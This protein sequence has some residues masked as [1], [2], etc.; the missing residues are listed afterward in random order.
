M[1]RVALRNLRAH[2]VRLLLSL[3]AVVLGVAFVSGSFVLTD[4]LKKTF[5]DLFTQVSSDVTVSPAPA[6]PGANDNSDAGA[7]LPATL[8]DTISKVPGVAAADGGIFV[9][10]VQ[11]I[12]SDGKQVGTSQAPKFGLD[13]NGNEALSPLRLVEGVGPTAAGQIAI[14]SQTAEKGGIKVGDTVTVLTPT[15]SGKNDVVGIFRFGTTGNLA[16]ASLTAF[17]QA[18]AEKLLTSPG[19]ITTVDIKAAD[20]VTQDEL[21]K[22]IKEVVPAG[23]LVQ[24]GQETADQSAESL[25]AGFKFFNILF[26]AF[27]AIALLVGIFLILNTFSMLVA[28]RARELALLRALGAARSQI[29]S[30]VLIEAFFVGLVGAIVGIVVGLGL[31][32][33]IKGA[34]AAFG[35]ELPSGPLVILPRTIVIGLLVG[36]VVTVVAA[37]PPA[38]RA[39][40]VPPVAAMRDDVSI[41]LRSLHRRTI[42]GAIITVLGI[43]A[44]VVGAMSDSGSQGAS[45]VGLGVLVTLLGVAVIAPVMARPFVRLLGAP[46]KRVTKITGRLAVDNAARNRRR[47]ASTA[48]AL[49]IGLAVVSTFAILAA[50]ISASTDATVDRNIGADFIVQPTNFATGGF[51][52]AVTTAIAGVDGVK[53]VTSS[54]VIPAQ[55]NGKSAD[56]TEIDPTNANDAVK[57][58]FSAG[59]WASL[60]S[61]TALLDNQTATNDGI[62]VGDT[63]KVIFPSKTGTLKVVGLYD[64]AGFLSGYAISPP[65]ARAGD[66]PSKPD[67]L[68]V[69][70]DSATTAAAVRPAV[71]AALAAYPNV[72]VQDQSEFKAQIRQQINSLLG[73]IYVLLFLSILIAVL[74]IVNTLA[75]SVIERRRE[76]GLL[77]AVG[78]SRRQVR[79]SV[80]QE[81]FLISVFG[82]VL[83]VVLGLA[84]GLSLQHV[85]ANQGLDV[86]SIPVGQLLIFV[87]V[88]G[89]VGVL[90]ALWPAWRGARTDVL[91]A[92]TTE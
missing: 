2:K 46:I 51:S 57:L 81:A 45:L 87:V 44:L 64:S 43:L 34:I 82:G 40:K 69:N 71:D 21:A 73:V 26:L 29:T 31:A 17:D 30:S 67:T 54:Q 10:G 85:L 66:V 76:I 3:L 28:Q 55:I 91:S 8:V 20:G 88:A 5:T 78:M 72:K 6:F 37:F 77:R 53:S 60:T 65:T 38:R 74:G 68:F 19:Q 9:N 61:G 42:A 63:V 23:V 70:V 1:F 41:P 14:D 79:S 80:R 16:G 25:N 90:A 18:T 39:S 52:P 62:A 89:V 15:S 33:G 75:L 7:T 12:G 58:T 35:I 86:L 48:S 56:V 84:F 49:M 27:A 13:W 83:G 11:V 32:V 4:T 59:S 50:S 47:T 92:I 22:R 24:T 36:V